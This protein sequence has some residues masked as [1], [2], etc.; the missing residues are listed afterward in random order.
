MPTRY[1]LL[2][3]VTLTLLVLPA[4]QPSGSSLTSEA[5]LFPEALPSPISTPLETQPEPKTL[6]ICLG[7]EPN[8]LYLYDSPNAAAHSVLDAIYDGPVD[9]LS[10]EPKPVILQ[11]IP[12]LENGGVLLARAKVSTGS[13]IVDAS[14]TPVT[15][16]AGVRLHPSGCQTDDCAIVYDGTS[17]VEMDQM[18][19]TFT[20][21]PGL[22]WSDGKPLTSAD[23]VY[24]Y[25][26]AADPNSSAPKYLID[27]TQSYEATDDLS[28]QWWGK[29]G[30]IDP[31][32]YANF[33]AP[34]PAHQLSQFSAGELPAVDLAARTPLGWGPYKLETWQ[35]GQEIRLSRNLF[36]FR[37][38]E[39]LP[40]F[41]QLIFRIVGEPEQALSD[42][43]SGKCDLLDPSVQLDSVTGLL[44]EL[45]QAGKLHAYFSR[46]MTLEQLALG[47]R[48]ASYDNGY[49]LG[50]VEDRPDFFADSRVRQAIALCL[51]RQ[52]VVDTVLYGLVNV[53]NTFVPE[54]HPLYN[55]ATQTYA[56]D[57]VKA[58]QLLDQAGWRDTDNDA[59]TPRV[60]QGVF[61]VR[62][63]TPLVL[64]YYTTGATQRR[65]VSEILSK[66]LQTCG[67]GV[68]LVHMPFDEFYAPGPD[69]VLFGRRFDLAQ[70]AMGVPGVEPPCAWYTSPEVP[71]ESNAWIGTNVSG[72]ANPTYDAACLSARQSLPSE[73]A[74]AQR[75]QE[76]QSILAQDLPF[77]PL[78]FR[79]K[80]AASRPDLCGFDLNSG[81]EPDLWS[82]ENVQIGTMCPH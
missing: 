18:V 14:G 62:A 40:A 51:D 80:V 74:Y 15:L 25:T 38:A 68:N 77:V 79:L 52:Q 81:N 35:S 27:R 66:S 43:L 10:Y 75:Y 24:A 46:T 3:I 11:Q 22:Y 5:T 8:T 49:T 54:G 70:F 19:V 16:T 32:F 13:E 64:N 23:S 1:P 42:L 6:T 76:A 57:P 67:I 41:D 50:S 21:L 56:Y 20:L 82:L 48:P 72:Y 61:N 4:C 26:L 65:Q 69:G 60:A 47:L 71:A 55:P 30:Y 29:P 63:G 2:L 33:W 78:Y 37:S 39:G 9:I 59:A 44:M 58:G 34:L 45:Q 53:P 73:P 7:Q 31:L 28:V 12:S 36:Y 17:P